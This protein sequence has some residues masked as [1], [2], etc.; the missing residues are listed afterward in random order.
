[1]V[2]TRHARFSQP[3]LFRQAGWLLLLCW[4]LPGV[5]AALELAGDKQQ[6][7]LGGHLSWLED[8]PGRLNLEQVIEAD[9][10][11]RFTVSRQRVPNFGFTRSAYWFKLPLVNRTA[12][13]HWILETEY[14][15]LDHVDVYYVRDGK[16]L[17]HMA[18]GDLLPF[19]QREIQHRNICFPVELAPGEA[20]DVY[21]RVATQSSLQLPIQLVTPSMLLQH[22]QVEFY[23]FGL[24][25]G[26]LLAMLCY[27][28]LIYFSIGDSN[29]LH[30]VHYLVGYIL[31]QMSLNGLALEFIWPDWP[32]WGNVA[33]PFFIGVAFLGAVTF[34]RRFLQL[35]QRQPMLDQ[36]GKI[37]WGLFCVVIVAS[38]V[39]DYSIVIQ[40]AAILA[41]TCVCYAFVAGL[42]AWRNNLKQARYFLL[43]WSALLLGI[44]LYVLKTFN[45]LPTNFVTEYGLQTGS[46]M[47]VIL[48]SFALAHRIKLTTDENKKVHLEA[49]TLLEARVSQRTHELDEALKKLSEANTKLK[50]LNFTD[51]LTGVRNRKYFDQ[52]I[53][54]EWAR[55][56]RGG[57]NLTVMLFDIDHFKSINDNFGHQAGDFCL[58]EVAVT[59]QSCLKRPCDVMARYGGEEFIVILPLTDGNGAMKVAE[60]I[61]HRIQGMGLEYNDKWLPVT[62]SIGVCTI[63]PQETMHSRELISAA[64]E[65]LYRAKREG[66]NRVERGD[67]LSKAA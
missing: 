40:A 55:A 25:Y 59:I 5:A 35:K 10:T 28:L 52:K 44:M 39:L 29:Y 64:D 18:N 22:D 12:P 17:K 8:K 65:A 51:G 41:F 1:M 48:L 26:V 16:L 19:R 42:V 20:M 14:P 60:G 15:M 33:T 32:A 47:E 61:R 34:V 63:V 46:V 38:L 37:I 27:N 23:V 30:Y 9:A 13:S 53:E 7:V 36:I 62:A 50:A 31:F 2:R 57:Y 24:Y 45:V 49:N 3:Y 43:A 4:L 54:R 56:Q 21:I 67:V 58:R 11:R 66:R 6:Y